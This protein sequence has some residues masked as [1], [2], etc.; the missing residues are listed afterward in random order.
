MTGSRAPGAAGARGAGPAP[1]ASKRHR[2]R[3]RRPDARPRCRRPRSKSR[4]RRACA[5]PC[6]ATHEAFTF[7]DPARAA[8]SLSPAKSP[9]SAFFSAAWTSPICHPWPSTREGI[10]SSARNDLWRWVAST[11]ASSR[12]LTSLRRRPAMVEDMP[13]RGVI[14]WVPQAPTTQRPR[15]RGQT[16]RAGL[17]AEPGDG[18][19]A[20]PGRAPGHPRAGPRNV[21]PPPVRR[22]CVRRARQTPAWPGRPASTRPRPARVRERYARSGTGRRGSRCRR[23]R[24]GSCSGR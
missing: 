2:A 24:T 18:S 13:G 17:R 6:A 16:G 1:R 7:H 12:P 9:A 22:S 4:R 11:R 20:P 10:T 19:E 5:R 21:P 3:A 14:G 15:G 23:S 8:T